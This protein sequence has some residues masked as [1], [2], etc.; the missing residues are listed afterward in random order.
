MHFKILVISFYSSAETYLYLDVCVCVCFF[1]QKSRL[2]SRAQCVR[3]A[4]GF[5]LAR[6]GRGDGARTRA[7]SVVSRGAGCSRP[8]RSVSL[9]PSACGSGG[10]CLRVRA[11]T[12]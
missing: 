11:R 4:V 2:R 1:F 10:G 8:R 7:S 5:V 9:R 12:M 6:P 3:V